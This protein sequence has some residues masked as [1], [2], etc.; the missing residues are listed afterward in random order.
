M[1]WS[2]SIK[3]AFT[4]YSKNATQLTFSDLSGDYADEGISGI[5]TDANDYL[6]GFACMGHN[7]DGDL[8]LG[9]Y[10]ISSGSHVMYVPSSSWIISDSVSE[11]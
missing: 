7:S 4:I 9:Y 2:S 3:W 11:V 8:Q 6:T 5:T 10:L 1:V